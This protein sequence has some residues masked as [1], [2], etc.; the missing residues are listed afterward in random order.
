MDRA[1]ELT[2]LRTL[3]PDAPGQNVQKVWLLGLLFVRLSF[4]IFLVGGANPLDG[5]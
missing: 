3:I 5:R 1:L 2:D 4:T